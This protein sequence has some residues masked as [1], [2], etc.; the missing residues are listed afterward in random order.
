MAIDLSFE[1]PIAHLD[2]YAEN[3]DYDFALAHLVLQ[4]ED[5]K[6][7][8]KRQ[9][10]KRLVILDNSMFE[11]G[12]PLESEQLVDICA[13]IGAQELV[14][15]DYLNVERTIQAVMDMRKEL[16]KK[17]LK[18]KLLGVVQ[19]KTYDEWM[20]CHTQLVRLPFV[21]RICICFNPMFRLGVPEEHK[22]SETKGWMW[23]RINFM[24]MLQRSGL[25]N[26]GKTY[27]LLGL[28]DGRE[29]FYQK[30][31]KQITTNDS[32]SP[33]VHGW[34]DVLYTQQGLLNEKIKEKVD[35][36]AKIPEEKSKSIIHNIEMLKSWSR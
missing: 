22:N 32:S 9:S 6:A 8:Y 21:D 12:H 18:V 29:L 15:P 26:H 31:I 17:K 33:I 25:M 20:Q 1:V 11:L 28:A 36:S 19:G 27:H 10:T 3:M 5:Y 35:F 4:S 30:E 2:E 14:A 24:K 16:E 23:T 34:N 7:Y 13:Q